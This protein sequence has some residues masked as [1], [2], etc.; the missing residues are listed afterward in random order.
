[1]PK[2]T[3]KHQELNLLL[4]VITAAVVLFGFTITSSA[5]QSVISDGGVVQASGLKG[6][7]HK[8][9][10]S[11]SLERGR[12]GKVYFKDVAVIRKFYESRNKQAFWSS[13]DAREMLTLVEN[14]WTHGLNPE[15]YHYSDLKKQLNSGM[16][17]S[18]GDL[19]LLL[20][21]AA[22]RYGQDISGMRIDPARINQSR[23]Y[24]QQP[25]TAESVLNL[26]AASND[27][28]ERLAKMAPQHKLYKAL[29]N[30]MIRLSEEDSAFDHILPMSFNG[31]HHFTP[32]EVSKD[33]PK[34]RIR[35]GVTYDPRQGAEN[36]YD[37][38][39]AAALMKFQRDH[40]LEPDGIVG[41]STLSVLNRT[42]KERMKQIVANLERQRW[43]TQDLPE[44]YMLVNIPQQLLWAVENGRV[45]HEMKVVVGMPWRR[46]KDFKTDV[47]GIRI[48]PRW[49]APLSIKMLDILPKVQ[50][51]TNYLVEK[52]IEVIRGYGSNAVTLDPY[53]IDWDNMSRGEMSKLRLV[54]TSG[55]HNAL[56][57]VR[58]LMPNKY[59]I[60]FHDTNHPEFFERG[61]RTYSSGCVRLSEPDK[62]AQFVMD[63]TKGWSPQ[64]LDVIKATYKETDIKIDKP[65]PAFIVYHTIWMDTNERI[66]YGPDVYKRDKELLEVLEAADAYRLPVT[67]LNKYAQK[68]GA[69]RALASAN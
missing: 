31:D 62:V 28:V 18:A 38:K 4:T 21:D 30:E 32:G 46:T 5:Q 9:S 39:T 66:V 40:N 26:I 67:S 36:Y 34:L 49:T 57:R 20:T 61:Q 3:K 29:Q 69:N 41:P 27:P 60:Y 65:F 58:I 17:T 22:I 43:L 44:K 52:G 47:T 14:S 2:L 25:Y 63:G 37:D 59:N 23:E 24:W 8:A 33:V 54:Q 53:S 68:K 48:N 42:N 6:M 12:V 11:S 64:D 10:I 19:E 15:D 16:F 13:S 55:D 50:N 56:G 35:L 45:K 51:D 1:M 7:I